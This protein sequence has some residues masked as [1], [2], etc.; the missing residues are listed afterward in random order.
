MT[1][2]K[3]IDKLTKEQEDMLSVYRDKWL[4]IGLSTE[5]V[6]PVEAEPAVKLMYT[7]VGLEPPKNIYFTKGPIEAKKVMKG[8]GITGSV[9]DSSVFGSQEAGWLSFYDFFQNE[10]NLDFEGKLDGLIAVAKTCGWVA[11]YDE[12]A[13]VQDRPEIIKMDENNRLHCENGPAVRYAD[14]FEVY[15][16][17]GVRVPAEWIRDKSLD[18]KT[19]ITWDNME[20][21]R[22]ACEILGW[23]NVLDELQSKVIDEDEDPHI[24]TLLVVEIPDIGTEKFLKVL[25]GTGRTFAIPVPPHM[26]SAM[27]ANCWTYGFTENE[28][29]DLE[30]RT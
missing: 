30:I 5:R 1:T 27:E 15:S 28:L 9:A 16:W 8:L 6:N 18:A 22:A 29:R 17:H 3:K 20:E 12:A 4:G 26:L 19:A 21:R 25:C 2:T 11:V 13:I 24:G 10:F 14:G 23:A 7:C